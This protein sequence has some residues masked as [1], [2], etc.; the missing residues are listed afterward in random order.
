VSP[1]AAVV[2]QR[3]TALARLASVKGRE[4]RRVAHHRECDPQRVP[5]APDRR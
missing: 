4:R 5:G 3:M 2:A 1:H